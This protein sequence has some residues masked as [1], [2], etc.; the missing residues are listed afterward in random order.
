[1]TWCNLA[2]GSAWQLALAGAMLGQFGALA[3]TLINR[4][5][6][7]AGL[8]F[9]LAFGNRTE[10]LLTAPLFLY[11]L[12]RGDPY[13]RPVPD[14]PPTSLFERARSEGRAVLGFIAFPLLLGLATL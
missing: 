3:F 12:V 7:L 6:L 11:L 10:I 5:P 9:A 13:R 14:A 8:C 2:F 1:W 4:Q